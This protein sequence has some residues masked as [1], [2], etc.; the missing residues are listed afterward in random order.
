[1][2]FDDV[3]TVKRAVEIDFGV[4]VVPEPTVRLEVANQTLAAV[5]FDEGEFRRPLAIIHTRSKALTPGM[6]QFIALLKEPA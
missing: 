5:R 1:M 4:S 6:K 3:E 2:E